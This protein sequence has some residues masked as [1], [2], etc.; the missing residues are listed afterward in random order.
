MSYRFGLFL[1][2][3]GLI[4][5]IIFALSLQASDENLLVCVGSGFCLV[6]GLFLAIRFRPRPEPAQR[7]RMINKFREPSPKD[8]SK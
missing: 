1:I 8:K 6:I 5:L 2:V 3:V 4:L 7:F